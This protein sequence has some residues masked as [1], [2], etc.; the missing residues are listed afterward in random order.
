MSNTLELAKQLLER[1]S[2]TPEDKGCQEILSERLKPLGFKIE[3]MPF[4]D[5]KNLWARIGTEAPLFVFAGH[6][7]V[8]LHQSV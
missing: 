8:P 4:G 5:V 6:T 7:D 1:Q 3:N 2:I